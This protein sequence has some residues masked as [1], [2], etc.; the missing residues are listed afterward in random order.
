MRLKQ[1]SKSMLKILILLT[2]LLAL[3]VSGQA[4]RGSQ[5]D[6]DT[7]GP[8]YLPMMVR[9][10]NDPFRS[11]SPEWLA[12]LNDM[13][14]L[15]GLPYL[16][17]NNDWSLGCEQHSRYMVLNDLMEHH[18]DPDNPWYTTAGDSAAGNSNLMMSS[19]IDRPET[20][21]I[22]LWLSG[23]FHG[24]GLLDPE[25]QRTGFGLYREAVGDWEFA[26]CLDVLRGLGP[27]PAEVSF[28][29][30]WPGPGQ[31][32]PYTAYYGG[33][34]PDPLSACPGYDTPSGPPIYLQ[35]GSG[36]VTPDVSASSFT[37]NG[38]PLEHCLY[39]EVSYSGEYQSLARSVL[40]SRDAVILI[41][42]APL[43]EGGR[44]TVSIT[45][46]G[47]RHTWSFTTASGSRAPLSGETPDSRSGPLLELND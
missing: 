16:T 22:D 31:Q 29:I 27:L 36:S 45:A 39:D 9:L 30:M 35:L 19:S 10:N 13:R 3:A 28:P 41:P 1:T 44:Y 12:Y 21:P 32:M 7:G 26:A 34:F 47:Q 23:P 17:E 4:V 14:G 40:N 20:Y 2:T 25:L 6:T 38:Q 11:P 5:D 46:N 43:V 42:R 18:E 37:H 33:E 15:A 24:L 8:L